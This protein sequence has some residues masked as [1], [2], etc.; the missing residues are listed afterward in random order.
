MKLIKHYKSL[1]FFLFNRFKGNNYLLMSEYFSGILIEE[2]EEFV[3][4]DSKRLL[5]I[6]GA[7][8]VFCKHLHEK[9]HCIAT[10]YDPYPGDI[11]WPKTIV[12]FAHTMP[13]KNN[14]FDVIICRGVLEHIQPK[15]QEPSVEEMFRILKPDGI[16]YISIPPWYNPHAGHH[17]KPFHIFPFVIAK[18][19]RELIFRNKIVAQSYAEATLYPITFKKMQAIIEGSGFHI[20]A[21]RDTH[22]RLHCLTRVPVL[23]EVAVPSAVFICRKVDDVS[24]LPSRRNI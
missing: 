23:R 11:L 5:D 19:L 13:F 10:N 1:L 8:G 7:R 12:G 9:R 20:I 4:L 6:G 17:L 24:C 21:T 14:L 3:K 18:F 22:F 2:L 16:C 15:D